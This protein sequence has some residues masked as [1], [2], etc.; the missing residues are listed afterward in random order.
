MTNEIRVSID[1]FYFYCDNIIN[2][3]LSNMVSRMTYLST[4]F[5][6]YNGG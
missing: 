3:F 1:R 5:K 4:L 6:H 2:I